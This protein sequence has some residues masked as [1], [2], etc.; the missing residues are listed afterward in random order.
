MLVATGT[1]GVITLNMHLSFPT[2]SAFQTGFGLS[3]E[4]CPIA[5]R[6][7]QGT[8]GVFLSWMNLAPASHIALL[9]AS[10]V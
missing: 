4:N 10:Q 6:Q 9:P 8:K 3:G 5:P 7:R 2:F 1:S